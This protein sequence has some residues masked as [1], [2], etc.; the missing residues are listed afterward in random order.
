MIRRRAG[1]VGLACYQFADGHV[2]ITPPGSRP[3]GSSRFRAPGVAVLLCDFFPRRPAHALLSGLAGDAPAGAQRDRRRAGAADAGARGVLAGDRLH[4]RSHRRTPSTAAGD[5]PWR[6]AVAAGPFAITRRLLA[7]TCR[8]RGV[9]VLL[10]DGDPAH[11]HGGDDWRPQVRPR[12]RASQGVGVGRL[13][14][15]QFRRWL[16]RRCA[17]R[18]VDAADADPHRAGC[19]GV[20][21]LVAETT[22]AGSPEGGDDRAQD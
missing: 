10:D 16:C 14:C 6:P 7:D 22:R 11:R 19:A 17:R 18:G 8:L 12:L 15:R 1:A 21:V 9:L 4:R 2:R 20:C 3:A 5:V 13:H